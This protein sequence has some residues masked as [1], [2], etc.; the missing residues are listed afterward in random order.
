MRGRGRSENT[1]ERVVFAQRNASVYRAKNCLLSSDFQT[2][3]SE[4]LFSLCYCEACCCNIQTATVSTTSTHTLNNARGGSAY[5]RFPSS[6]ESAYSTTRLQFLAKGGGEEEAPGAVC[7]VQQR[8]VYFIELT[9]ATW[10]ILQYMREKE[11]V[12]DG[13]NPL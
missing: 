6:I 4:N 9:A 13:G 10:R 1:R 5:T 11:Q 3:S 8:R 7:K 12:P 2:G